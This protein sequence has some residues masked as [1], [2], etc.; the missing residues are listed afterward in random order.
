MTLLESQ[1]IFSHICQRASSPLR[2]NSRK[3]RL[4]LNMD[5][6]DNRVRVIPPFS[7]IS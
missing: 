5:I 2:A 3:T 4:S 1:K 6:G 7:P